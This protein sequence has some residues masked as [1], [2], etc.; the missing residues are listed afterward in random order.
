MKL[1]EAV[2]TFA[3]QMELTLQ[4]HDEE[5]G[6]DGWRGETIWFL[7]QR[8][9]DELEELYKAYKD[10]RPLKVCEEAIDVANFCMM[11]SDNLKSSGDLV[12]PLKKDGK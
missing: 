7:I 11:I 1:R 3:C 6:E 9:Q 12:N 10:C 8:A 2:K 5:R 4:E